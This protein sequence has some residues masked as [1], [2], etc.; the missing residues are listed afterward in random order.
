MG[1]SG[2]AD[3]ALGRS[4]RKLGAFASPEK[5][6]ESAVQAE[7]EKGEVPRKKPL[8]AGGDPGGWAW[9]LSEACYYYTVITGDSTLAR[10]GITFI[11][12]RG[13]E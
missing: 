4:R 9:S 2:E 3:A 10:L 8:E 1:R 13:M 11:C 12:P 5:R 6:E 7:S